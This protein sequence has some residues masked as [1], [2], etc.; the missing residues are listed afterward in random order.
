M[1]Q[2]FEQIEYIHEWFEL[3]R[4]EFLTIP[5]IALQSM[6]QEWQRKMVMLLEELDEKIDWRPKEGR[7][8]V[9]LRDDHGKLHS[10]NL[11]S[12]RHAYMLSRDG[13]SLK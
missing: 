8:W 7:Y 5:R 1:N 10:T 12:Y 2:L 13:K 3:S 11:E 9:F 6:P 4:A